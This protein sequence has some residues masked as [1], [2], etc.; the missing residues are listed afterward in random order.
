[1]DKLAGKVAIV[2]GS[3]SG[4]GKATAL[5]MARYGSALC[6]VTNDNPAGADDTVAQIVSAG[7]KAIFVP[8]DVSVEAD[9]RRIVGRT[10]DA[11]GCVDI[12]VNNA[13]ITR[14]WPLEEM[15]E[16]QWDQ[17]LDTNLKSVYM[18]SRFCVTDML[19]RSSGSVVSVSSVHAS[20]TTGGHAA[21]AASKAGILGM[22]RAL[23]CEFGP[24][25]IRFNA[26]APGTID[27]S[28]Y[29]RDNRPVDREQWQPRSSDMQ[30]MNRCGSPDEVAAAVCFLASD[31]ASFINGAC[32]TVDGGLLTHLRDRP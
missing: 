31:D 13:G 11:F 1:M 12:L 9:C 7:G 30:V 26:I 5:A 8:A 25:G 20:A 4:I 21:Y 14:S 10:I 6:V 17:V 22:T 19:K 15:E 2:T 32:L 29:P 3:S 16:R 24:R 27:I 18:M 28:L 23:A